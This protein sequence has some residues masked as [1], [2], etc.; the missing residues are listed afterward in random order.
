MEVSAPPEPPNLTENQSQGWQDRVNLVT[1][2]GCVVIAAGGW[3]LLKEFAPVLRPLLLAVFLCYMILPIH[4]RLA[5][6]LP[7]LASIAVLAGTSVGILVL[8][9]LQVLGSASKLSEE[10]PQ[11]IDRGQEII[12]DVERV[13][14]ERLPP[15]LA[16]ETRDVGRG[17]SISVGRLQEIAKSLAASAAETVSEAVLVGIYLIFLLFEASRVGRKI[18][19]SFSSERSQQLLAVV[20]NINEAMTS[21]LR[22]KVKA[23]LVLAVPVTCVLWAFG[24]KSALMWGVLT[25][26]LNF[27]PY[28]GSVFACAAPITL[29]FLQSDSL[30]HPAILAA[31]LISIHMLSAYAIEPAMTGKAVNLSPLVI[32]V[33]L[34]FWWLCWGFIGMILAVPLTVLMKIILENVGFTRPVGRL[35]AED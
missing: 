20:A 19:T 13:Y 21:Y 18:Q 15:W 33:S 4:R 27:V 2:A 8:L 29:S 32:L 16:R 10:M 3:Y 34:A 6:R 1:V 28:L 31:V 12:E 17:E 22:V 14:L 24:M 9:A 23:S 35:M 30:L 7:V 25:F 11:M 26:L 5:Q